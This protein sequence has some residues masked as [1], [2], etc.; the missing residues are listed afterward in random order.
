[1]VKLFYGEDSY[2]LSH[3]LKALE[4]KFSLANFGDLNIN[5]FDGSVL[6]YEEFIRSI[7]ALPFLAEKRL[8][9]I[10]NFLRD[11]DEKLREYISKNFPK[12]PN[13]ADV[14]LVEEGEVNK[15]LGF[16]K[17]LKKLN[18]T[19]Y[20]PLRQGYDLEK[21]LLDWSAKE[22]IR[23]KP[24]AIRKLVAMAGNNSW[25]LINELQKLDVF[26]LVMGRDQ[27]G[28]DDIEEMVE[29]ESNPNI[30]NFI[31]DLGA[32]DAKSALHNLQELFSGG[33]NENYILTMVVYQFRNMLIVEDLI[34]KGIKPPM[35]AKESDLHPFVVGKTLKLLKT[36]DLPMLRRIYERLLRADLDIKS[37]KVQPRLALEKLLADLTI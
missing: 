28:E 22:K 23:I 14:I 1:M 4:E 7:S 15:N 33:K 30:F 17:T 8:I 3:E 5:K 26:R 13:S 18:Q 19:S 27:I 34:V 16:F 2:S 6:T 9:I 12:F 25:R 11:G 32:R 10:K 29:G 35:I 31:D 20:F 21:W 37:G 24:P 36:F